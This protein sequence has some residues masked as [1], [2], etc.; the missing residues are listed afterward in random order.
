[1]TLRRAAVAAAALGAALAWAQ[2]K[3][4]PA[5][6][7]AAKAK[8]ATQPM[9]GRVKE[10]QYELVRENDLT[11]VPGVPPN[12][13]KGREKREVCLTKAD[14]ERGVEPSPGCSVKKVSESKAAVAIAM[15]CTDGTTT[16][17]AMAFKPGGYTSDITSRGLQDGKP[18]TSRFHSEAKY[19]GP[20]KK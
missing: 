1:M 9:K 5:P 4:A 11:E 6:A 17:L 15:A 3:T 16:D 2:P 14:I 19:L 12:A 8:P 10:G 20:C 13:Q 7:P 18:F